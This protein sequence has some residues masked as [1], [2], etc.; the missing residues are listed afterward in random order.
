MSWLVG[1]AGLAAVV[2]Y[3]GPSKLP[4]LM[5]SVGAAG[6]VG[7]VAATIAARIALVET[8]TAPLQALGYLLS[9]RDAFWI[10]WIRTFAN[11][12]FPAAGM[13]AYV[14][15]LRRKT[16]I[17]WSEMAA[18]SAPQF[19]LAAGAIA[20]VGL[21]AL[22]LNLTESGD[23][24]LVLMIIYGIVLVGAWT[25]ARGAHVLGRGLPAALAARVTEASDAL[26]IL[27]RQP[28]LLLWITACHVLAILLRGL[29]LWLLFELAGV[30]IDW[31]AALLLVAIA[32]SSILLQLTP[33]GLGVREGAVIAGAALIGVPADV[34]AGVAIVD[35]LLVV[36]ITALLTPPAIAAMRSGDSQTSA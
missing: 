21:L 5:G 32:E 25:A 10:G 24:G 28:A 14:Q 7:W 6:V 15:A 16:D 19:I 11:Q 8:T 18:M 12:I 31:H 3:Y 13:V 4:A 17:S 23:V 30:S 2:Y 34:A 29:R 33:G 27:A 22:L 1:L 9:R 35:R 36:A 26:R 20:V